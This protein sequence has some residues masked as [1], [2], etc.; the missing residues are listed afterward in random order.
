MFLDPR[1]VRVHC[2]QIVVVKGG[3]QLSAPPPCFLAGSVCSTIPWLR[4]SVAILAQVSLSP[5]LSPT[6]GSSLWIYGQLSLYPGCVSA[7]SGSMA[8]GRFR[9]HFP[10]PSPERD[11]SESVWRPF[12][13]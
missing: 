13:E 8:S 5:G 4:F 3:A 9:F 10:D 7:A 12:F 2:L 1:G 6:F 11:Y